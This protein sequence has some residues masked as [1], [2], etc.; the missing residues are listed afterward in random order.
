[1]LTVYTSAP[2]QE[3][4]RQIERP[5][6]ETAIMQDAKPAVEIEVDTFKLVAPKFALGRTVVGAP[7][8]ATAVT[9]SIQ[10]LS[11]GNQI[12]RREVAKMYRDSQ[13]RTRNEGTVEK[14]G[15]WTAAGGG[16]PVVFINDPVTGFTYSLIPGTRTAYKYTISHEEVRYKIAVKPKLAAEKPVPNKIGEPGWETNEAKPI[17]EKAARP[18]GPVRVEK[19]A[20]NQADDGRRKKENLGKQVIEGVEAEGSRTTITIPA[21]EIG[22]VLPIEIVDETWYSPQLQMTVLSKRTD[23]RVGE[24]SY[25]LLN[26]N[27][28]EPDHSLFE[29]GSDYTIK[30]ESGGP[31]KKKRLEEQE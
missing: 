3:K 28:N 4:E 19:S 27:R 20:G 29:V 13:G 1:M 16:E 8:S 7:F 9:E 10:T 24:T 12:V 6:S 23:P 21:G 26:I 14:I 2:A 31:A 15:K 11:D 22:N 18:D 25:R 17:P 5:K 30:D